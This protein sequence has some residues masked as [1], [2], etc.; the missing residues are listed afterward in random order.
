MKVSSSH[1]ILSVRRKR[2]STYFD[3]FSLMHKL[4]SS[5]FQ[6]CTRHWHLNFCHWCT[7]VLTKREYVGEDIYLLG[8]IK[9]RMRWRV[10]AAAAMLAIPA[11]FSR[12]LPA[13]DISYLSKLLAKTN[14]Y[15]RHLSAPPLLKDRR[16]YGK[17]PCKQ[18]TIKASS[19]NSRERWLI[20]DSW[21]NARVRLKIASA[22]ESIPAEEWSAEHDASKGD[23]FAFFLC[24]RD[25][26]MNGVLHSP[27][28]PLPEHCSIF[29]EDF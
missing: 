22:Y 2:H 10:W 24:K 27:I 11:C 4:S 28:H 17:Q 20:R 5:E 19:D 14:M 16:I 1:L 18:D 6:L 26:K 29:A 7:V 8:A 23:A 25:S 12:S 13:K 21:E 9:R 15:D 3:A